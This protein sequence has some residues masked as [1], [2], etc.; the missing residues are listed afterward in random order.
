[1]LAEVAAVL[2]IAIAISPI[3][4]HCY[5][6]ALVFDVVLLFNIIVTI[7]ITID[8]L[9]FQDGFAAGSGTI[10]TQG[11]YVRTCCSQCILN[12]IKP[13]QTKSNQI[14][15]NQICRYDSLDITAGEELIESL[16][17]ASHRIASL[18]FNS[19]T[20]ECCRPGSDAT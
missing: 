14:K 20:A 13:N 17:A 16:K 18:S 2:A 8:F 5:H 4:R 6:P 15:S 19:T 10:V 9:E 12:Q 1:M 7:T 11:R 3:P